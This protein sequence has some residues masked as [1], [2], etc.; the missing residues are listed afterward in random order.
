MTMKKP[1]LIFIIALLCICRGYAQEAGY[2]IT[3]DIDGLNGTV[4]LTLLPDKEFLT[5]AVN[6]KFEFTGRTELPTLA[7]I[8]YGDY[9]VASLI[10]ENISVNVT[11]SA[12]HFS[13]VTVSGSESTDRYD[14]FQEE[15]YRRIE[16]CNEEFYKTND[17]QEWDEASRQIEEWIDGMV[18]ANSDNIVGVAIFIRSV[19]DN[20]I[21][22]KAEEAAMFSPEMQ[23]TDIIRAIVQIAQTQKQT[24]AGNKFPDM[25][26]LEPGGNPVR[27]SDYAGRGN[28]LLIDFWGSGCGA[29]LYNMPKVIEFY[30]KYK[31][32]G[33][34]ILGIAVDEEKDKW[35][36]CIEKYGIPW[37]HASTLCGW[38][39]EVAKAYAVTSLPTFLLIDPDGNI[40]A[41]DM[42]LIAI[43]E[44]LEGVYGQ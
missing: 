13:E 5:E 10:L 25:E 6:G 32:R 43:K 42:N 23:Q 38:K 29:C 33:F 15:L 24:T 1:L 18:R 14:E 8:S 16:Q 27:I 40:V 4:M 22:V 44:I 21:G 20:N 11:G 35:L 31:D 12:D 36:G 3:G 28:Y 34:E 17:R 26:L 39:C 41:R 30:N 7:T 2:V 37:K 19:R 9:V